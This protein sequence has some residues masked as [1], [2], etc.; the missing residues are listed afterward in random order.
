MKTH[1][2]VE[3]QRHTLLIILCRF[4]SHDLGDSLNDF[5]HD[6]INTAVIEA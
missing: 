4:V 5:H 6:I 1:G 2:M 3:V